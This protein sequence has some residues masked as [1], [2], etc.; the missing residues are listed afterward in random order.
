M[1]NEL[2]GVKRKLDK[3]GSYH[4]TSRGFYSWVSKKKKDSAYALLYG[5]LAYRIFMSEN[6]YEETQEDDVV[7]TDDLLDD[8]QAEYYDVD[9]DDSILYGDFE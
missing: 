6:F 3:D 7:L 2:I 5:Y 4:T 1:L 8:H 9:H